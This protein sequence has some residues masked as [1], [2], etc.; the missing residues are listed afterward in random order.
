MRRFSC[1]KVSPLNCEKILDFS[2]SKWSLVYPFRPFPPPPRHTHKKSWILDF[3][4]VYSLLHHY[5]GMREN[6]ERF[7][8]RIFSYKSLEIIYTKSNLSDHSFKILLGFR[9]C[10]LCLCPIVVKS[11]FLCSLS[12]FIA[13]RKVNFTLAHLCVGCL[14]LVIVS[15]SYVKNFRLFQLIFYHESMLVSVWVIHV[16]RFHFRWSV[17]LIFPHLD[18]IYPCWYLSMSLSLLQYWLW[19]ILIVTPR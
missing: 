19:V 10:C 16:V 17:L 8:F 6:Y 12:C 13:L 2:I 14:L 11:S 3:F 9:C 1:K 4:Y 7:F 18:Y 5:G 15:L